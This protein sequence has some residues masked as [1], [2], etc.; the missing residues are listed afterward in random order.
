LRS[1]ALNRT[2]QTLKSS[3]SRSI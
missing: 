1:I 3:Q 2:S